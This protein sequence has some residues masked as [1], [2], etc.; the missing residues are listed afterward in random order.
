MQHIGQSLKLKGRS[1]N[2]MTGLQTSRSWHLVTH[3]PKCE[4][5]VLVGIL[6]NRLANIEMQT[7]ADTLAQVLVR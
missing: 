7:I 2:C 1:T 4:T 3:W 6:P 5:D